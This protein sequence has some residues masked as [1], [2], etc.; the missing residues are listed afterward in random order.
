MQGLPKK[1]FEFQ[2][3][4][5]VAA[6]SRAFELIRGN[7]VTILVFLFVGARSESFP[8]L[9]WIG[10]GFALLLILGVANWWRFLYK[11][12][13][14]ELHIKSGIFVR[15]NLYLTKDR[16]QVID[17]TSG[18]IQRLF[19]LV[20]LDIQTAGSSS[21]E[22]TIEAITIEKA[23]EINRILRSETN[24]EAG[25]ESV[26]NAESIVKDEILKSFDLPGKELLIAA[27]TSGSF[28][29]ALSILATLF[30]QIEPIISES[31]MFEYLFGMLPSQTDT[32]LIVT[33]III[34]VV[35]AWLISF[36][37]TLFKYGDFRL[38]VKEKEIVI[39]RGIFEKK[40]ITVPYNRIQAIHVAEGM[41]RQPLGYA[42]IQ[43]ESAGYGDDKGTGSIVL[44][45]LIRQDQILTL[46]KDVLP[47]YQKQHEGIKPPP[48]AV[49]RYIFRSAFMVTA[50]TAGL[51]FAF[52]LNNWIWIFPL[53]SVVWGWLKYKDAAVAWGEDIFL[54]RSR[55]L[56][57]TTAFIRKNRV[58]DIT[59][60]QSWIQRFRNLCTT[61]IH[62]ASGDQGKS[63]TVRDL[64]Y[65]EAVILLR[66][67]KRNRDLSEEFDHLTEPERW[68]SVPGWPQAAN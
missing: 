35:C 48:R 36:F 8:F 44:F 17:I 13:N 46:L 7:L 28:G 32:V 57:K 21:R 27:S 23:K 37:S 63:F 61:Q 6:I 65:G 43:L 2:R 51:Y 24:D 42:S 12:E 22:A 39:S 31:E 59:I 68:I 18:V 53:L 19:G 62:V 26:D 25:S 55:S 52:D 10:G 4:H 20:K 58:Q 50:I 16:I 15:K 11:I 14:G 1:M 45:P 3:Q 30:S 49:R 66:E 34:F 33:V 29:I 60:S 54:F 5:P 9:W 47:D 67:I 38:E 64:E 41:I 56:S 40:R